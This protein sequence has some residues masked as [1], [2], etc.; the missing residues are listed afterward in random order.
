MNPSPDQSFFPSIN[1]I[2]AGIVG[3]VI[4]TLV[5]LH[6]CGHIQGVLN[7]TFVSTQKATQQIQQ[8]N[9]LKSIE[10]LEPSD[11]T[12]ITTPDDKIESVCN[13]IV[14]MNRL[15]VKGIMLHCSGTLSIDILS[16]LKSKGHDVAR[17]HPIKHFKEIPHAVETFNGTHCLIE[18][19]ENAYSTLQ[20]FFKSIG[21]NVI[22]MYQSPDYLYHTACVFASVFPQ[23]LLT[24]SSILYEICG[25]EKEMAVTLARDLMQQA[26]K[27]ID[28]SKNYA[29]YIE[30]PL[31]RGDANTLENNIA[32]ISNK[33]IR[34]LYL[35][36]NRFA[37]E[38]A[39]LNEEEKFILKQLLSKGQRHD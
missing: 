5:H 8:G 3:Q 19:D 39:H 24:A 23:M 29:N 12:F 37:L 35:S 20:L 26:L 36:F 10:Q 6:K 9:P 16:K 17:V 28:V 4:G 14:Q 34:N 32:S 1:I 15:P 18:S 38:L 27:S 13:S 22:R 33:N 11:I 31:K 7:S 25:I 30:G 21:G 2:G